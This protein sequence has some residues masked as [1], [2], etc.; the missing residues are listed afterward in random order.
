MVS[1]LS[2]KQP[3][4]Y[5]GSTPSVATIFLSSLMVEREAVNF[6]DTRPTRVLGAFGEFLCL[7][8]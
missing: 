2:V 3:C 7:T 4:I 1:Q 8:E 5:V 6:G